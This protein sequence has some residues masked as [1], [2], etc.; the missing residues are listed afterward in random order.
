MNENDLDAVREAEFIRAFASQVARNDASCQAQGKTAKKLRD[1]R[2]AGN[3][4]GD[5]RSCN[6]SRVLR[7]SSDADGNRR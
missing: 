3:I 6:A 4:E 2:S 1:G 7:Q 5:F